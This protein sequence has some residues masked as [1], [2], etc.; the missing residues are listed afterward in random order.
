MLQ[1]NPTRQLQS[2][3]YWDT[4]FFAAEARQVFARNWVCVATVDDVAETG[5][6]RPVTVAGQTLIVTRAE[7]G[8]VRVFHNYCRHRG[9]KLVERPC[10]G[11]KRLVCPY[12]AWSYRLDGRLAGTPHIGGPNA[13]D[14]AAAGAVLPE[15]LAPVR[16]ALWHHLIFVDL[17][18]TAGPLD[19]LVAPLAG[20]W[21]AYDLSCLRKAVETTYEVAC[22]WK[23]A[24]ENFVDVYHLPTVHP[25]LNSYNAMDGHYYV[26]EQD[27]LFGQ[28]NAHVHPDDRAVGRLPM[29]PDL[30]PERQTTLD[31]FC[32][33]PNLLITVTCDHLRMI[34]VEP[35]GPERCR[36]R[37]LI[38][39]AGAAAMGPDL[40]DARAA[41]LERFAAFND[42]DVAI[43]ERL[44]ASMRESAYESGAFSPFF[45]RAVAH[46][47]HRIAEALDRD[48]QQQ[49]PP[50][51]KRSTPVQ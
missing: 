35:L 8:A 49:N 6:V 48:Y 34:L 3:A 9:M 20:L 5:D 29:F 21:R 15:G 40:A 11:M 31:A 13:H 14:P 37:V 1:P 41:L 38:Y 47:Q 2:T 27:R 44:Q 46:F 16:S 36:E 19:D 17:S 23:L 28:G 22:N 10:R 26:V 51:T 30:P 12:H 25:G 45:D 50:S 33:F 4:A 43:C 7:D 32:L 42:E 24:V 39:V 18:G